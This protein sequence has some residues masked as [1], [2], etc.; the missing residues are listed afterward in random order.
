MEFT[1][2][3]VE[4]VIIGLETSIWIYTIFVN[5]SGNKIY[6]GI[7]TITDSFALS[8]L[9]IGILY[10]IGIMMDGI[11]NILFQNNE[12][13]VRQKSG[14]QAKSTILIWQ[15]TDQ[16]KKYFEYARSRIRILRS[17]VLNMPLISVNLIWYVCRFDYNK[18]LSFYIL[19]LGAFFTL[20]SWKAFQKLLNS[21]YNKARVLELCKK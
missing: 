13:R 10:V 17:S 16:A 7:S 20:M 14:L 11:A 2:L 9:L 12:N 1:Q 5:I 18:L 3:Y 8:V 6:D 15:E 4:M 21:Y 19:F